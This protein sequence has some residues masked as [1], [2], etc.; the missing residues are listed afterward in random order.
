MYILPA[1]SAPPTFVNISDIT[2]T[3]ITVQWGP[4]DC[5]HHNGDII[6][7]SVQY[8]VEGSG[9]NRNMNISG[10]ATSQ[11]TLSG[12]KPSTN[13]SIEVAAVNIAGPGVYSVTISSITLG[14]KLL[15]YVT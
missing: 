13:Y 6:G 10:D 5:I 9:S 1:P 12:L 15:K 2:S 4:V 3:S 8:G 14:D 7:Y 11:T